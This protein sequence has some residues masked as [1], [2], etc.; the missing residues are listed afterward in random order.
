[1][2]SVAVWERRDACNVVFESHGNFIGRV[3]IV[4]VPI[5]DIIQQVPKFG[6]YLPFVNTNVFVG[7]AKRTCHANINI[8]AFMHYA[9]EMFRE[10][11]SLLFGLFSSETETF[12][13]L[14]NDTFA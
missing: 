7:F 4:C 3:V 6:G 2:A 10:S 13:L 1:M 12:A 8:Q 14:E 5:A 11:I 9:D